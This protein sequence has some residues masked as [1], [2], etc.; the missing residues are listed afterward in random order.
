MSR[1]CPE[2]KGGWSKNLLQ[3]PYE[4]PY[5]FMMKIY[6]H[7]DNWKMLCRRSHTNVL[8]YLPCLC[9]AEVAKLLIDRTPVTQWIGP[10]ETYN[11]MTEILSGDAFEYEPGE[12]RLQCALV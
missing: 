4:F 6:G 12:V 10:G 7:E 3:E 9:H 2:P 1:A 5:I 8:S 11:E